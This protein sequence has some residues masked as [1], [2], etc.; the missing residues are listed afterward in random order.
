MDALCLDVHAVPLTC[1]I[2]VSM[3]LMLVIYEILSASTFAGSIVPL[4]KS[5][6]HL[7]ENEIHVA[8]LVTRLFESAHLNDSLITETDVFITWIINAL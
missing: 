3:L 2:L 7:P 5:S 1:N 8:K 6:P 4:I